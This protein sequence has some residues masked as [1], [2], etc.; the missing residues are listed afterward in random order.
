MNC[1]YNESKSKQPLY[2]DISNSNPDF[3]LEQRSLEYIEK[4]NIRI[5]CSGCELELTRS[6]CLITKTDYYCVACFANLD[7]FPQEYLVRSSLKKS[8]N[9]TQWDLMDEAVLAAAFRI[10]GYSNWA[11]IKEYMDYNQSPFSLA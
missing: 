1:D 3:T 11:Q 2:K 8:F 5:Y 9:E 4:P 10:W 7:E 6:I